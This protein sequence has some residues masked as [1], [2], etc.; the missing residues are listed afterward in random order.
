MIWSSWSLVE[1]IKLTS[2]YLHFSELWQ[3]YIDWLFFVDFIK[4]RVHI[5]VI[6]VILLLLYWFSFVIYIE[7]K[8]I[9]AFIV[10]LFSDICTFLL[11]IFFMVLLSCFFL[12]F[13]HLTHRNQSHPFVLSRK[14]YFWTVKKVFDVYKFCF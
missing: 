7:I 10:P 5:T 9:I 8:E 11:F 4:V 13:S 1:S 6:K 14:I 3:S 2:C 12:E